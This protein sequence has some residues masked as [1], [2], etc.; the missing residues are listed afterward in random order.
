MEDKR[1]RSK[2]LL[3]G[4]QPENMPQV[5]WGIVRENNG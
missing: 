4:V 3:M 2:T 1:R 5:G